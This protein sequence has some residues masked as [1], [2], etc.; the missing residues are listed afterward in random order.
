MPGC[1]AFNTMMRVTDARAIGVIVPLP[2][3]TGRPAAI[4]CTVKSSAVP[5]SASS[6]TTA[7][8]VGDERSAPAEPGTRSAIGPASIA[9]TSSC[10]RSV[11]SKRTS[12]STDVTGL[13]SHPSRSASAQAHATAARA[14]SCSSSRR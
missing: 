6:R 9:L 5:A 1:T 8:R 2:D 10:V 7:T 13:P 3:A 4:P 14:L 12:S 11:W